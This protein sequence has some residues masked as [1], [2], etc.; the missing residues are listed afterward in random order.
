MSRVGR[1]AAVA[2]ALG[3]AAGGALAGCGVTHDK[4]AR[5]IEQVPFGLSDTTTTSTTLPAP[6]TEPPTTASTVAPTTTAAPTEVVSLF[7]AAGNRLR[8]EGRFVALPASGAKLDVPGTMRELLLGPRTDP[9]LQNLVT[10]DLL[11]AVSLDR[12]R[13]AVVVTPAFQAL[14]PPLQLVVVGQLVLTLT[15]R[16]GVGHVAFVDVTGQAVPVPRA[17]GSAGDDV[18][19]D[20]YRALTP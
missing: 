8:S 4:A 15:D 10:P 6:P 16:P 11:G 7:Y 19:A 13:V 5:A 17:D 20:D 2:V 9:G 12:G 14:A 3:L 1:A 18:S